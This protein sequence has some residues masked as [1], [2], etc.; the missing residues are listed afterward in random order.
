MVGNEDEQ[1]TTS[2]AVGNENQLSFHALS[3][4]HTCEFSA[5]SAK[6]EQNSRR[7]SYAL[8]VHLRTAQ[9]QTSIGQPAEYNALDCIAKAGENIVGF[10]DDYHLR[11]IQPFT[12]VHLR[13]AL[14]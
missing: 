7:I 14:K 3:S 2:R 10:T 5:T 6:S 1:G 4:K 13:R 12:T 9:A 8:A 11:G